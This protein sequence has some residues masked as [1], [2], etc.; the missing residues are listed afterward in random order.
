ML[1]LPPA[2]PRQEDRSTHLDQADEAVGDQ[3][4]EDQDFQCPIEEVHE[5]RGV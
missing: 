5:A 1:L 4:E 3:D 2:V